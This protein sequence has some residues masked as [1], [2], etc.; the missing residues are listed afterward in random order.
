MFSHPDGKLIWNIPKC[1]ISLHCPLPSQQ[2]HFKPAL[3]RNEYD[4]LVC[5]SSLCP[6]ET[7][8]F[9]YL[10]R[11]LQVLNVKSLWS[12]LLALAHNFEAVAS[13]ASLPSLPSQRGPAMQLRPQDSRS[14]PA[15]EPWHCSLSSQDPLSQ[16]SCYQVTSSHSR[17][18]S[19]HIYFTKIECGLE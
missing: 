4:L 12:Q 7:G 2:V 15:S 3:W 9:L 5:E 10:S 6:T 11:A 13:L 8:N 19:Y 1:F 14:F 17:S 16:G 18:P